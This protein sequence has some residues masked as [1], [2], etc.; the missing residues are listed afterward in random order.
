M[1]KPDT[2]PVVSYPAEPLELT[3][4]QVN[5]LAEGLAEVANAYVNRPENRERFRNWQM[6]RYGNVIELPKGGST[7]CTHPKNKA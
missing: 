1:K 5:H 2:F 3:D 4:A 6:K 7:P